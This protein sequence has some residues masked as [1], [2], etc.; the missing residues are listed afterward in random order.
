MT[1]ETY[2]GIPVLHKAVRGEQERLNVAI[3]GAG[4]GGLGAAIGLLLA[5]HNVHVLESAPQIGEIGA[6]IQVLPNSSRVLI[7]WGLGPRLARIATIPVQVE[8]RRWKGDVLTTM[9]FAEAAR[10]YKAPFWD[11]H[12]ADLHGAMLERAV[13]LGATLQTNARVVDID[14]SHSEKATVILQ[15]GG[16][17]VADLVIGADG[18][19]SRCRDLLV[20]KLDPPTP[21]GDLAYRVL[22]STEGMETD[23]ELAPFLREHHVRYWM[24]PGAHAVSYV[25]RNGKLINVVLLVPDDIPDDATTV[26]GSVEEM[27]ALYAQWDPRIPKL[28]KYCQS[29]QKWKLCFRPGLEQPWYNANGTFVLLGDAVHA[30]LPYL[31]SGAGMSLEDGAVLGHCFSRVLGKSTASKLKAL[32]VYEDCRRTRTESV[33]DRGNLQ[34]YLYHLDDGPE[35]EAR[36]DRYRA[37][38]E[39]EKQIQK[40][41]SAKDVPLPAGLEIGSDPFP[42]RRYGV[43]EWLISYDCVADVDSKWPDE[44]QAAETQFR[45]SL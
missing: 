22:L 12:R 13:E 25:L 35:Q 14:T 31:A 39:L 8:M 29:V 44:R 7:Q 24:G 17:V 43:G 9:D 36:D 3:V 45:A 16:K 1:H 37:F 40:A 33:V 19:F 41:G 32:S 18:I 21:T 28:L 38:G 6:G 27:Q 30:T 42:W 15:S 20:G 4:L 23:P 34:Q 2:E 11:F 5:G 26:D 10:E